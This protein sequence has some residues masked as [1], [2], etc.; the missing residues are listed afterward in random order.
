MPS[1]RMR[2][3][4]VVR[5]MAR[6]VAAPLVPEMRHCVCLR[7][8]RMCWRSA[9]SRVEIEEFKEEEDGKEAEEKEEESAPAAVASAVELS[10]EVGMRSSL[11]GEKRTERSIRFS[12]SRTLPGQEERARTSMASAGVYFTMLCVA[13]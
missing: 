4:S 8:R 9:S 13:R 11:A 1:L 10:S 3:W 7:A 2:A 12:S 5:F 6:S